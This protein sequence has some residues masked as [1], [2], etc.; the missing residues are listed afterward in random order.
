MTV[1]LQARLNPALLGRAA[2]MLIGLGI[3]ALALLSYLTDMPLA[4]IVVWAQKVF[5][6]GFALIFSALLVLGI[7]AAQKIKAGDSIAYWYEVG[8]QAGNGISTLALT[9]TLLGISLGIGSLSD[10][11]LNPDNIQHIIGN[12][13]KQFS[14]AFMTTVVGLPSASLVRAWVGIQYQATVQQ[15]ESKA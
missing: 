4:D 1:L 11:A 13:T 14:T 2:L 9:F 10:Q 5:G 3:I 8:Q 15:Q 6:W 12:L 7:G